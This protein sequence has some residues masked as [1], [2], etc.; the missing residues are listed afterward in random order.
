MTLNANGL[1]VGVVPNIGD[2][3]GVFKAAG[4]GVGTANTRMGIDTRE[5]TS[6]NAAGIWMGSMIN[7]NT[8]VIGSRTASGNI[9]FQT[10]NGASWGERM[11]IDYLGNLG[12][13]VTP[14]AWGSN[15]TPV[16]LTKGACIY[17][18]K[19]I[20]YTIVGTNV[21]NDATSEKYT[22][23]PNTA[24][25]KYQ[26]TGGVHSWHN[27]AAGTA[28]TA[29]TF[30]QAMTLD[31]SG[32]LLVGTVTSGTAAGDGIVKLGT[33]GHCVS[34]TGASIA[35]GSSVD[36]TI[37][38]SGAGYQGF[39]SVANTLDSNANTRTQTTF[40]VFGRGTSSTITQIATANGSTA[41]ASFT[42]TTPSN[43]VI[44][45]TNTS[46]LA[47]TISAQFFGGSS[48]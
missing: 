13:G 2:G 6:G 41:G 35:S 12:L 14:S 16:E 37:V 36:L 8:G 32:R 21:Y 47:A 30:T 3:S 4:T 48:A 46:G 7:E 20:P 25:T 42:V 18:A 31:A 17:G 9:A 28:G 26:Q 44:R 33:Y 27:A 43:G 23:S 22:I 11:R 34:Q 19:T 1:G 45:I 24:A 39:L 15:Y 40:S 5:I 38:T 29:I 10:F